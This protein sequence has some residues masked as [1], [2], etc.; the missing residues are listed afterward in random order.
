MR[1][2]GVAD[3]DS[4]STRT[5]GT[6][7][8]TAASKRSLTPC[9][10]AVSNSSSPYWESSCLFALTTSLPARIALSRYSRAGSI[11]PISSTSR[12]ASDRISAKLPRVRVSTPQITGLRPLKRAISSALSSSSAEKAEPTVPWPSRPTLK[13][14]AGPSPSADIR[15]GP[16]RAEIP[17]DEVLEALAPDHHA[18]V[19]LGAED[20]R[21]A[22]HAVVVVGHRVTVCARRGRDDHVAWLRIR[23][24]RVAHDHVAGLA[25]L[26]RQHASH[27]PAEAVGH[28]RFIA[29]PIH[30]RP[31]VVGHPAV[32]R[33]PARDVV[34]DALHGVQRHARVRAQRPSRLDQK[35]SVGA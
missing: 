29:G 28:V 20:H 1:S 31:Q 4:S 16:L 7:P 26:A 30:H 15:S 33:N 25:V 9:S 12:S 19:A 11:P 3:S 32:D 35:A 18:R 8:A 6:A 24:L 34:L 22:R 17:R 2:M 27:L 14:A 13:S 23:Q 21:R 10:R 5:T